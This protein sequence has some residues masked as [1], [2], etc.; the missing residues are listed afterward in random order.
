MADQVGPPW[1]WGKRCQ[2]TDKLGMFGLI[3]LVNDI[4]VIGD[5]SRTMNDGG[6]SA[7]KDKIYFIF[8]E[9]RKEADVGCLRVAPA[10]CFTGL[11]GRQNQCK[12][13]V[14]LADP[15]LRGQFEVFA[16]QGKVDPRAICFHDRVA[17]WSG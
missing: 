17:R 10:Q 11:A 5:P 15:F 7:H 3:P 13:S 9:N 2:G 6:Q 14:V 1:V 12:H 8:G 16:D 4:N